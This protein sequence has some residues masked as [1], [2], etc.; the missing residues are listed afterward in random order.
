MKMLDLK[1]VAS[2]ALLLKKPVEVSFRAKWDPA[3]ENELGEIYGLTASKEIEKFLLAELKK[4]LLQVVKKLMEQA[5][6]E[7]I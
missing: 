2:N 4:E 6:A 7:L 5:K 3:T 1:L